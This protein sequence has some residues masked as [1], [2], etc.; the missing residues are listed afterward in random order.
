MNNFDFQNPTRILFGEGT[1]AKLGQEAAAYGSKVLLMYGGG[2]IKRTG[3][4][5]NVTAQLRERG[6]EVFEVGGVEPN[7]RLS[8]VRKAIEISR[9][10]GVQFILAVGGGSAIDAAKAVAI[11]VPYEGDVWDFF[12]QKAQAKSALPLGT[13]LTLSA[14]G[15]EMNGNTVITNW[16]ENLK[17]GYGSLHAYPKFSILDPTL[18]YTVPA[19]QTMNGTVDMMTHVFEQYFS[20]TPDTPLQE[21]MCESV[22]QT[23]IENAESAL[24]NPEDYVARAN[25]MLCGTYALNGGFI[26]VGMRGDWAS[27]GIEHEV[28]GIYDIPHGTGLAIIYPNW[29]KYVYRER[30][31]RFAQYAV[32]VWK[33]N[34]DG[35][36]DEE[37]ALAGIQATRDFFTRIGAP[38][39]LSEVGVGD[40]KI[41]VMA[42]EAVR[43]GPI[44]SFK[45]LN[46][47]DVAE[48]Y[49]M[50]L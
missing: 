45:K 29:M 17:K 25:L 44:G 12:V 31:E 40:E 5:D 21:R 37:V 28:S 46:K 42:A 13:V 41:D 24:A 34:P 35:K 19:D 23:V 20:L 6:I 27:H 10:N 15:T 9:A 2:S 30:I 18:T 36:T 49:R 47:D 8:T 39:K 38:S 16:E 4:Y 1:L 11:G 26:S 43:F 48:I 50:S 32:R 3:L 22:L 7:P 14:T 33:V